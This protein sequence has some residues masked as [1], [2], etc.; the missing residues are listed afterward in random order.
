MMKIKIILLLGII[1]AYSANLRAQ[2]YSYAG[3]SIGYGTGFPV[4]SIGSSTQ[5]AY[6][7]TTYTLEKGNYGQGLNFSITAGLMFSKNNGMEFGISYLIGSQKELIT[8]RFETD[9]SAGTTTETEGTITLDK[10]KMIRINPSF[11]M[12]FGD[13]ARPYLRMGFILGLGTSYTRFEESVATTTGSINDT[14][15]SEVATEYSGGKAFGFNRDLGC[16]ID[17]SD[18]LIFFE[19]LSFSSVSW[20]ATKSEITRYIYDGVDQLPSL[21]PASLK[22]QYVDD[23]AQ[24]SPANHIALKTYLPFGCFGIT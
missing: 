3:I 1:S 6:N 17:L 11:K 22:T 12:T 2:Q 7:E 8:S 21:D 20:A 13:A 14:V 4:Y 16:D 10:I 5:T 18:N 24:T 15:A 19:E 23:Y 9:T